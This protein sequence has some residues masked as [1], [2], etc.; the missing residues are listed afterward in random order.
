[1]P[2]GLKLDFP[3]I[4]GSRELLPKS[5]TV[6]L[7]EQTAV[8]VDFALI[9]ANRISGV[10][11]TPDG[12][13]LKGSCLNL[14][15]ADQQLAKGGRI[16]GCSKQ[17]G[18][19]ELKDMPAGRYVIVGN[20][21]GRVSIS[22]PFPTAYYPGVATKAAAEVIDVERGKSI[23]GLQFRL[24]TMARQIAVSGRVQF[25][26]GVPVPNAYLKHSSKDQ[27]FTHS[28]T[29]G[30]FNLKLIAEKRGELTAEIM[31]IESD[32]E[33]CPHWRPEGKSQM[34]VTLTSSPAPIF[35]EGDRDDVLLTMPMRSCSAWPTSDLR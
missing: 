17:D 15:P 34:L 7:G 8:S 19:F 26:D 32:L 20:K 18:S 11:L 3:M 22:E 23:E 13:P 29:D 31:A 27:T 2:R 5:T 33:K 16:F 4:T 1:M 28:D 9:E 10:L 30:R 25:S 24:P 12:K 35:G 21:S 6:S 14:E